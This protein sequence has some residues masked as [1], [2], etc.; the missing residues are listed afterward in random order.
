[1]ETLFVYAVT[2]GQVGKVL[3]IYLFL[4]F[5]ITMVAILY[6]CSW[7]IWRLLEFFQ[8]YRH[9]SICMVLLLKYALLWMCKK[10][11]NLLFSEGD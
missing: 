7:I 10:K 8:Y 5:L 1:M 3:F 4:L 2:T 6:S 9:V 11:T